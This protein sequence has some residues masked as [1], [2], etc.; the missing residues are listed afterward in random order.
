MS[1]DQVR[2]IRGNGIAM[3]F[4][5]PMSSLNPSMTVGRQIMEPLQAHLA[6]H[7]RDA[8]TRAI[9]LLALVGIPSPEARVDDYPHQFSG[10]M[11]QRV[12]IA[13]ALSCNPKLVL[14]DEVTTALDVTIQAQILELL[15]R[16]ARDSETAYILI[17][18]D[19]GV[20]AGMAQ[21]VIVMYAGQVVEE[22]PTSRLFAAP[23]MPY[24]WGLLQSMPR[25]D[26][27]RTD[28]LQP[29]DG[30]PPGLIEQPIG[31][32]FAPRCRYRRDICVQATPPLTVTHAGPEAHLARC[33]G[34]QDVEGGGWL[35]G[36]DWRA[37]SGVAEG[38]GPITRTHGASSAP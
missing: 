4:Q 32:R 20:V 33:W 35:H 1:A 29:I 3:V 19:L 14:A 36:Y 2:S 13:M 28:R 16:V 8:R 11:R 37:G 23:Q 30:M 34:T 15:K 22:A 25:L 31:C 26:R 10:G 5:D 18:H 17:T 24:T 38:G 12:M 7:S 21:R 6:M 9:E 27:E